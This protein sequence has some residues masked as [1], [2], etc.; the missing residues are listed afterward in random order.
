MR[1]VLLTLLFVSL[2]ASVL[3]YKSTRKLIR[4][5]R[6]LHVEG[7]KFKNA[8]GDEV[9]FHGVDRSGT[10]FMCIQGYGIFDGPSNAS[11]VEVIASWNVNLVRVPLNED[12]WLGINGVN[13]SFG[14]Q[15]YQ[16][17]IAE[18]VN[19]LI[20]NGMA[21][22]LDLH[23]TA[24]GTTPATGQQ[25][26]PDTDH[27]ITFWQQVAAAYKNNEAVLFDLF[28][29]PYPDNNN[30]NSVA[31]WTCWKNG[32]SCSG[33][34][35]NAAG[36]QDLVTAVRGAGAN[37]IITL[38]GI[39]YSN[40]LAQWM[41]YVPTD[42]ANNLAASWHSYNFNYCNNQGC[43]TE[44]VAPL[45]GKYPIIATEIGESDC[46]SGYIDQ[47]MSF[48]DSY[49]QS[50]SA[51]TWNNWNCGSGPALIVDYDGTPTNYGAGYKA[52][53]AN[54]EDVITF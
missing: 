17:A 33:V 16:N 37:N 41:T 26:M 32:G 39:A 19:T 53:L 31:G 27:S 18:W 7:D 25:P 14:G 44:Y 43:W 13:A 4:D 50:Y 3:A 10:E 40:S 35:Y 34:N 46:A 12:C 42:P 29:E 23:W 21:V 51:W 2:I 48:L 38:G 11:S 20:T 24:P 54:F 28:N 45:V 8:N 15:N 49:N 5:F 52:H 1:K 9:V 6:G 36:M 22:V 47:V 30:W